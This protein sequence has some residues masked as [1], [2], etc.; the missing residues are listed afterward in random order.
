MDPKFMLVALPFEIQLVRILLKLTVYLQIHLLTNVSALF[1]ALLVLVFLEL[2]WRSYLHFAFPLLEVGKYLLVMEGSLIW[3]A[4]GE[5]WDSVTNFLAFSWYTCTHDSTSTISKYELIVIRF[6]SMAKFIR[7]LKK[8]NSIVSF[9][10][11]LMFS[12]L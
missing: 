11:H 3:L 7:S 12:A 5:N 4:I 1:P 9:S 2:H 6:Y 10:F 8:W